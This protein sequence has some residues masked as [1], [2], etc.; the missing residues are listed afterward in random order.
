[1][2]ESIRDG[3]DPGFLIS[4]WERYGFPPDRA[5]PC[6]GRGRLRH[7]PRAVEFLLD[8]AR[9]GVVHILHRLAYAPPEDRS[10]LEELL[11]GDDGPE[12]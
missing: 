6:S 5:P 11:L 8:P 1:M 9:L 7:Y 10:A 12:P 3:S 4:P 2:A